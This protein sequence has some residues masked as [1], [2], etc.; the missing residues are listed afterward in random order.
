MLRNKTHHLKKNCGF[1]LIESVVAIAFLGLAMMLIYS[2]ASLTVD[3]K[4]VSMTGEALQAE[5]SE[6]CY[7]FSRDT[8]TIKEDGGLLTADNTQVEL[9]NQ[10]Y[11]TIRYWYDANTNS[12][13]RNNS[14]LAEGVTAV[15]FR[16]YDENGSP[17]LNP[18]VGGSNQT[19]V[20]LFD[21]SIT[22]TQNG[23]SVTLQAKAR[24]R[25]LAL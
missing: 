13:M 24:P 16:Y 9:V 18:T 25:N 15:A 5:A 6:A 2:V 11:Q 20:R 22:V 1:T 21:M 17:V 12:L 23:K 4:E 14:I 7:R 3:L 19:N 10:D 8:R